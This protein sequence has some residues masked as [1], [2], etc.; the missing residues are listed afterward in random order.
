MESNKCDLCSKEIESCQPPFCI[1]TY[2][3]KYMESI[4][5]RICSTCPNEL[6][7]FSNVL[8]DITVC[9][10]CWYKR[11]PRDCSLRRCANKRSPFWDWHVAKDEGEELCRKK[12]WTHCCPYHKDN[13]ES[14]GVE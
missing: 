10:D 7:M 6:D 12:Q 8:D 14:Y 2:T 11:C 9:L 5:K 1:R 4:E 3:G 13:K